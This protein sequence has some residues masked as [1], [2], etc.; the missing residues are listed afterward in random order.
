MLWA[1]GRGNEYARP[2][3]VPT[4]WHILLIPH[5]SSI[6]W[7][8]GN[9]E[10]E[11]FWDTLT[12]P[13]YFSQRHVLPRHLWKKPWWWER[14]GFGAERAMTNPVLPLVTEGA[15][16]KCLP[17]VSTHAFTWQWI[18]VIPSR[19]A[20]NSRWYAL[21]TAPG[22]IGLQSGA[23]FP[24][25]CNKVKYRSPTKSIVFHHPEHVPSQHT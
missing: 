16:T 17:S 18:N 22:R 20:G 24:N 5:I 12:M 14:F 21:S 4:R 10:S 8:T 2:S 6:G 11:T 25:T 15:M 23:G 7:R 13:I 1:H 19:L 9:T 3:T